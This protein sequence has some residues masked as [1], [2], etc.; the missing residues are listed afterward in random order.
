VKLWNK[1]ANQVSP[2]MFKAIAIKLGK[3]SAFNGNLTVDVNPGDL[4]L[5]SHYY[6]LLKHFYIIQYLAIIFTGWTGTQCDVP[7]VTKGKNWD[8]VFYF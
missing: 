2:N 7:I 8:R 6:F 4:I 5:V 3:L 1:V